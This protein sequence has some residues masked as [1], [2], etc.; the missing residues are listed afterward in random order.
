MLNFNSFKLT[1]A[2][3]VCFL[4]SAFI[5]LRFGSPTATPLSWLVSA[6]LGYVGVLVLKS[7]ATALLVWVLSGKSVS[8][9][10]ALTI[11]LATY[12]VH[13]VSS[14]LYQLVLA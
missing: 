5:A 9:P 10:C 12:F 11:S 13:Q 14:D 2:V 4:V 1:A 7:A 3:L 6:A 8:L